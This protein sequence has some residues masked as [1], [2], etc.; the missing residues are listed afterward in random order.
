MHA[1]GRFLTVRLLV[2]Q[3][4]DMCEPVTVRHFFCKMWWYLD[5][6]RKGLNP[7]QTAFTVK[8]FKSHRHVRLLADIIAAM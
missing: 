1:D 8:L 2:Q 3:S 6:Y 4:L 7:Q 5:A